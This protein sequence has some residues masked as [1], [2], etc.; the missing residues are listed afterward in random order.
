MIILH[1]CMSAN[2]SSPAH[3]FARSQ[4]CVGSLARP[5]GKARSRALSLSEHTHTH[6]QKKKSANAPTG[7]AGSR[8][9]DTAPQT[10]DASPHPL[11]NNT[12]EETSQ[13]KKKKRKTEQDN[14][15]GGNAH[16]LY[17]II[18]FCKIEI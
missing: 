16:N 8:S 5:S 13:T 11:R 12:A 9:N 7:L 15:K 14:A 17:F 2:A 18:L 10:R 6:T 1:E 3:S 4:S